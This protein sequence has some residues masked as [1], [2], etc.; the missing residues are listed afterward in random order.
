MFRLFSL[1]GALAIACAPALAQTK[2]DISLP[3]GPTEFHT[4]NAQNFAR[5]VGEVTKGQVVLTVHAGGSLGIK[6]NESIRALEDGTVGWPSSPASR[7]SARCRCWA[8]RACRSW[9]MTT[10]SCV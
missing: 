10:S 2:L 7:M 1:V 5:R 8:S 3:W 9:S 4:I 6:A